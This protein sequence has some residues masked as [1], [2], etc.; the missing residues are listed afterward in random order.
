[1]ISGITNF[2]LSA[3]RSAQQQGTQ[4]VS[5]AL[6]VPVNTPEDKRATGLLLALPGSLLNTNS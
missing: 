1:L 3:I 5:A 4:A 6:E 2:F